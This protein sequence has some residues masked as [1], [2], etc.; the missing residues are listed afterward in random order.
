MFTYKHS[1]DE[2]VRQ[3]LD[4]NFAER[5]TVGNEHEHLVEGRLVVILEVDF[6]TE[7]LK[8][9]KFFGLPAEVVLNHKEELMHSLNKDLGVH[10]LHLFE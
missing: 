4:K 8:S 3:E 7:S 1:L 5:L 6:Q 10:L 2:L 9:G